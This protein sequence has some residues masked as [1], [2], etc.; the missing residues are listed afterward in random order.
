MTCCWVG[1]LSVTDQRIGP[2]TVQTDATDAWTRTLVPSETVVGEG[3]WHAVSVPIAQSAASIP[4]T[5]VSCTSLIRCSSDGG[6]V[7]GPIL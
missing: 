2:M 4:H 7:N 3:V 1:T 5:V 6:V